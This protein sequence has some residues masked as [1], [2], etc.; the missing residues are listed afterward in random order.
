MGGPHGWGLVT[1]PGDAPIAERSGP[2]KHRGRCLVVL[3]RQAPTRD[4]HRPEDDSVPP[5]T[6][7][8]ST[9]SGPAPR[10]PGPPHFSLEGCDEG[11][12]LPELGEEEPVLLLE[13]L[14]ADLLGAHLELPEEP[15]AS[16]GQEQGPQEPR[17]ARR[18][19]E[20][21]TCRLR[22]SEERARMVMYRSARRRRWE[23]ITC[24][25][26]EKLRMKT[27]PPPPSRAPRLFRLHA[28]HRRLPISATFVPN[29]LAG[30]GESR[31]STSKGLDPGLPGGRD[32]RDP[33]LPYPHQGGG[34]GSHARRPAFS[35][36]CRRL[37]EPRL[38]LPG[39]RPAPPRRAQP[40]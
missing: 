26:S 15:P 2:D 37:G 30:P 25:G 23:T 11:R 13:A 31:P 16:R 14:Q 39:P 35:T 10:R 34:G 6:A 8:R 29:G 32:A 17:P 40:A 7:G 27:M 3:R 5:P 12:L 24:F 36:G 1:P 9:G 18:M 19:W 33:M 4:N 20:R 21:R 22:P 38:N 28:A